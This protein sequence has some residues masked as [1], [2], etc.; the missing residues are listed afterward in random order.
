MGFTT[1][2]RETSLTVY[3]ECYRKHLHNKFPEFCH[4][5]WKT[6]TDMIQYPM[7]IIIPRYSGKPHYNKPSV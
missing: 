7:K 5:Y 4:F 1:E 2:L 6:C 3:V